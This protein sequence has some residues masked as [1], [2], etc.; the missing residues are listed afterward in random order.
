[1]QRG[2]CCVLLLALALLAPGLAAFA[3][4]DRARARS[5]QEQIDRCGPAMRPVADEQTR[6][7]RLSLETFMPFARDVLRRHRL[8]TRLGYS[9]GVG[10]VELHLSNLRDV[11]L[12]ES[13]G[14]VTERPDIDAG[15]VQQDRRSR[16]PRLWRV[17][18]ATVLA[19]EAAYDVKK[20]P[21]DDPTGAP[22]L[23]LA[24]E[25]QLPEGYEVVGMYVDYYTGFSALALQSTPRLGVPRHRIYALAGTH[26]FTDTDLRTWASGLTMGTAQ[27]TASAALLMLRDAALF[28]ADMRG[29]GEVFVTGQSQ[30]GLTAQGAGYLLE[31]YLAASAP[32]HHLTHVVAWGGVGATESLA[33][34]IRRQREEGGRGIWDRLETHFAAIDP[35]HGAAAEVWNSI[36][37]EWQQIVPGEEAAHIAAISA[38]QRIVGYFFE[39]D[40]FAR[41][42]SFTGTTFA[43]PTALILPDDCD[44]LVAELVAGV[45]A[46]SF[47][48][49]LESHFLRGY[50]RAVSR[51][52]V[53]L[54]RPADP[55][56]WQW[57]TDMLPTFDSIGRMWLE[58]LYLKG[59]ASGPRNWQQ[60]R[61]A[62]AWF[63]L[64]NSTC[65]QDF[66]PGCGA[67]H[68]GEP[69]WCLVTEE[70]V[71]PGIARFR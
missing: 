7:L 10:R 38:R 13:D 44:A 21:P 23:E 58:A 3:Q 61:A 16:I 70:A 41:G 8:S 28:A 31:T 40:L 39:I 11:E 46:G 1:M 52:A 43:F 35:D 48:V 6:E 64:H 63:T 14:L 5:A 60:C 42:G 2:V 53:G 67:R 22:R 25:T 4:A 24:P 45:S 56:K 51:G 66:W 47:G 54:A 68:Q 34:M 36:A 17:D 65:H 19:A 37:A 26:V 15:R 62:G 12:P 32:R 30:G 49:R 18:E 59:P 20:P 55:K 57:V 33:A 69:N 29:G 27:I 50:R 71:P 9:G